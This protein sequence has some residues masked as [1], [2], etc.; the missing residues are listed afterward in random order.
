[1]V[2]NNMTESFNSWIREARSKPI[3]SM[4]EDIRLKAMKRISDFKTNHDKWINDWSPL[5]ME[6]Y[7]DNKEAASGCN[8]IFNGDV[9]FEI[10]EGTD[11]H[12]VVLDKMVC[13]CRAWE[14]TGIPCLHAICAFY[15]RKVDPITYISRWYHKETYMAAYSNALQPVPGKAF[16]KVDD[17]EPILPPPVPNLPGRPKKNR[18][19]SS[20]EVKGSGSASKSANATPQTCGICHK[21]GHKRATC[22]TKDRDA[23][24][25]G[26]EGNAPIPVKRP[27]SVAFS[28]I[29]T[30]T[31]SAPPTNPHTNAKR[32]TGKSKVTCRRIARNI[33]KQSVTGFGCYVDINTGEKTLNPGMSSE[34]IVSDFQPQM[35]H[36]PDVTVRFAIPNE[37]DI[38]GAARAEKQLD[39][40]S[41]RTIPFKGDGTEVHNPAN[42]PFQPP[43]L[44]WNGNAA[45][46]SRQLLQK[47]QI[48]RPGS[49][50]K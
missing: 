31:E 5:C 34:E 40:S 50:P 25:E 41:Y 14:L 6:Y 45:I 16:M 33:S 35:P 1:M 9:G 3:V 29:P 27:S 39:V 13:T 22:L 48:R 42:L 21:E 36:D 12:T 10:G 8:V 20:T 49:I 32:S 23:S 44:Q 19:R 4:L 15:Y 24:V 11:K 37:K 26:A 28:S 18:V 30:T 43:G 2:D 17:Y 47:M 46:S 7:Q 38:R